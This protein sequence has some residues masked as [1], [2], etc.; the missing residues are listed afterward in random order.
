MAMRLAKGMY[1]SEYHTS[2]QNWMMT[3]VMLC[4]G[5]TVCGVSDS[6][7]GTRHKTSADTPEQGVGLFRNKGGAERAGE[8][9]HVDD[10]GNVAR[11]LAHLA[12]LAHRA[13]E[14][15][16]RRERDNVA[17]RVEHRPARRVRHK[18]AK[19]KKRELHCTRVRTSGELLLRHAASAFANKLTNEMHMPVTKQPTKP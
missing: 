6:A 14:E 10:C 3:H 7:N 17:E 8:R 5:V 9:E 13:D 11:R 4:G 12:H 15:E 1:E 18:A 2:A 16:R 19:R